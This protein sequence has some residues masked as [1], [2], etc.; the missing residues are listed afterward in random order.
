MSSGSIRSRF[1]SFEFDS[2]QE[3]D[4][5]VPGDRQAAPMDLKT[6]L[7][8]SGPSNRAMENFDDLMPLADSIGTARV[9]QIG[10]ASHSAGTD[11]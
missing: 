10:E 1:L 5:A 11:W 8:S 2:G 4:G 3:R 7:S 6:T 9:V